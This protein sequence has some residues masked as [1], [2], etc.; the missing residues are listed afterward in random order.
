LH[1]IDGKKEHSQVYFWNYYVIFAINI[2]SDEPWISEFHSN[3]ISQLISNHLRLWGDAEVHLIFHYAS[4]RFSTRRLHT[5]LIKTE[6]LVEV[7]YVNRYVNNA[8]L[9]IKIICEKF[10]TSHFIVLL[11]HK[12]HVACATANNILRKVFQVIWVLIP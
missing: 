7:S 2:N 9:L 12:V 5:V 1:F 10:F 6:S 3:W 8:L 11:W 4:K